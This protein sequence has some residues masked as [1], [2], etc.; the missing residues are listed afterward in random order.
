MLGK[1]MIFLSRWWANVERK[2]D[3]A[4]TLSSTK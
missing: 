2:E 4:R 1:E 3:G